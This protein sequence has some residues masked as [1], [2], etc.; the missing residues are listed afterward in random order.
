MIPCFMAPPS[1]LLCAAAFKYPW[2]ATSK[3]P[4]LTGI[5]PHISFLFKMN[6]VLAK[7]GALAE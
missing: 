4:H 3:M 2:D 6:V 7:Q 1:D 5:P